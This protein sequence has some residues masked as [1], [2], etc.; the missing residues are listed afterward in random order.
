MVGV[1]ASLLPVPLGAIL[2]LP[3][4][5]SSNSDRGVAE[6]KARGAGERKAQQRAPQGVAVLETF[7]RSL[8]LP[9]APSVARAAS[10][11]VL[12]ATLVG[13]VLLERNLLAICHH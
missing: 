1:V 13:V 4:N 2:L 3:G 7:H 12:V 8:H 6:I 5:H 9:A 11:E 10:V